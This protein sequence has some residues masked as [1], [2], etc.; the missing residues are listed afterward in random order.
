MFNLFIPIKF[1]TDGQDW[2]GFYPNTIVSPG[3]SSLWT[4]TLNM[5]GFSFLTSYH[6]SQERSVYWVFFFLFFL[7]FFFFLQE[8]MQGAFADETLLLDFLLRR[9]SSKELI[10]KFL[11]TSL[12]RK[13]SLSMISKLFDQINLVCSTMALEK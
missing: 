5:V 7:S 4:V 2:V 1:T 9:R 8:N 3:L 10:L 6:D 12:E 13:T 11:K